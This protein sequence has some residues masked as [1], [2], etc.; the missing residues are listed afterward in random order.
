MQIF[1]LSF[2]CKGRK[3]ISLSIDVNACGCKKT[4]KQKKK[5]VRKYTSSDSNTLYPFNMGTGE[6]KKRTSKFFPDK[7][8][9]VW[10]FVFKQAW[11]KPINLIISRRL[12][13]K[14]RDSVITNDFNP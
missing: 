12:M 6:K 4:N 11:T 2:K 1:D 14:M 7:S 5:S 3:K 8:W 10:L 13:K 9:L